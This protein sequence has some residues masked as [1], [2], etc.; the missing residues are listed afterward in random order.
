MKQAFIQFTN[1]N[2]GAVASGSYLPLGT[3]SRKVD[4][5]TEKST[6]EATNTGATLIT[7]NEPGF[8][9]Y[10]AVLSLN[11]AG[12][13][14]PFVVT[15]VANGVDVFS[16]RVTTSAAG[17]VTIPIDYMLRVFKNCPSTP[18]NLP[19]NVGLRIEGAAIT[20]GTS[21]IQ[22]KRVY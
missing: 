12:A 7:I 10:S 5:T 9:R 15:L 14:A 1:N 3:I 6:Y 21:N 18:T 11:L 4:C 13:G 22:V 16:E 2:I 19:L 8:Y 20:T 17:Y